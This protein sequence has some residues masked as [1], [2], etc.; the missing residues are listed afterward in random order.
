MPSD[1]HDPDIRPLWQSL[2][3]RLAQGDAPQDIKTVTV[4]LSRPARAR[5]A[6]WLAHTTP[7]RSRRRLRTGDNGTTIP[8]PRLLAALGHTHHDLRDLVEAA[9]LHIPDTADT[10]TAARRLRTEIDAHAARS[11]PDTPL[12][13][14]RLRS[15]GISEDTLEERRFLIDALARARVLLPLPRPLSLA[16]LAHHCAGD[17]HYFDLNDNGRGALLVLMARDLLNAEQPDTPAGDR[18]LLAR[19]GII[20]DRLSQTVL[21]FNIQATG[22]GP[23]DRAL[24][25]AYKD[26][27]PVHLTLH[28]LTAHPPTLQS[29]QRLLVVENVSLIDEALERGITRPLACTRGTLSAVDHTLL[30]LAR[31]AG[32]AIDYAGDHDP[33]GHAIA[34]TVRDR[35]RA[36]LVAMDDAAHRSAADREPDWSRLP[37]TGSETND[38]EPPHDRSGVEGRIYQENRA[39][40]DMLLGPSGS[41]PLRPDTR[42][43]ASAAQRP[44]GAATSTR[45]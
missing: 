3:N 14:E 1:L 33:W 38:P 5:I 7:Q 37:R 39:I 13:N 43:T 45:A 32:L 6:G 27:R 42:R 22:D 23:S 29:G 15:Y 16:R 19:L 17:P 2:A 12:L 41:D 30:A 9:G 26:R 10:R 18:V 44:T 20:A 36:T 4:P 34:A 21:L 8:V 11:L 28:D 25:L 31:D 24:N 40:I 35:Y